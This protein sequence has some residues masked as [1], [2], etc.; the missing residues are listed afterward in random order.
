[1]SGKKNTRGGRRQTQ[2]VGRQMSKADKTLNTNESDDHMGRRERL[3]KDVPDNNRHIN[4]Y[5]KEIGLPDVED[6]GHGLIAPE[7]ADAGEVSI[8]EEGD[9]ELVDSDLIV[10]IRLFD[11]DEDGRP[12]G[13]KTDEDSFCSRHREVR[14]TRSHY[15]EIGGSIVEVGKEYTT[16]KE[17]SRERAEGK[18]KATG[19][20]KSIMVRLMPHEAEMAGNLKEFQI[21]EA[22]DR[23]ALAYQE[24]TGCE[25]ISAAVHRMTGTDLHIHLQYC[26]VQ[27]RSERER[28]FSRRVEKWKRRLTDMAREALKKEGHPTPGPV[29]VSN[30]KKQLLEE[31][32][33]EPAPERGVVWQKVAGK[34]SMRDDSILGYSLRNKLN[35]VRAAEACGEHDLARKVT[36]KNDYRSLCVPISQMDD[37][38][39]NTRYRDLWLER[40][41]RGTIVSLIPSPKKTLAKLK[42]LG[43]EAARNYQTYG[44][45]QVEVTHLNRR[46]EELEKLAAALQKERA[47]LEARELNLQ[48]R[49]K[50]LEQQQ[51]GV[52]QDRKELEEEK[53]VI[54]KERTSLDEDCVKANLAGEELKKN[55]VKLKQD[56]LDLDMER[57]ALAR[58]RESLDKDRAEVMGRQDTLNILEKQIVEKESDLKSI[59]STLDGQAHDLS[60]KEK[61]LLVRENTVRVKQKQNKAFED[62]FAVELKDLSVK[63]EKLTADQLA[64]EQQQANIDRIKNDATAYQNL[65]EH[66]VVVMTLLKKVPVIIKDMLSK[67]KLG[68]AISKLAGM[69]GVDM[70]DPEGPKIN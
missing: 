55:E 14:R 58:E 32:A 50:E 64:L 68:N 63:Q 1:M 15:K 31:R 28:E 26:M 57:G 62:D 48:K 29:K 30:K 40:I 21:A 45:T 39:L 59:S 66:V 60:E 41:W 65:K 56:L 16:R 49:E 69:V 38:K 9:R 61:D 35:L 5:R 20:L 37:E 24:A 6:H 51:M 43:L 11:T 52:G 23:V 19:V 47:G 10:C 54:Q 13:Q 70:S 53:A 17:K 27:A 18:R 12:V 44:T 34:R 46:A 42:K 7:L 67:T 33:I 2:R 25:V 8:D 4:K 36:L 3:R 22:V